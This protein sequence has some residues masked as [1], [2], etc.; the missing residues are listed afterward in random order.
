STVGAI[1]FLLVS[2]EWNLNTSIKVAYI[3]SVLK[4]YPR[5]TFLQQ[6][7]WENNEKY[8]ISTGGDDL[9]LCTV[10]PSTFID[11]FRMRGITKHCK[12]SLHFSE[13]YFLICILIYNWFY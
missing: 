5:Q 12:Y 13:N 7:W 1:L 3:I 2:G 6:F 10:V 9:I 4:N 11:T 8:F